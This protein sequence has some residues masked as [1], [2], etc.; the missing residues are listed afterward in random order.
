MTWLIDSLNGANGPIMM[1]TLT[2][3]VVSPGFHDGVSIK[4]EDMAIQFSMLDEILIGPEH[5]G[6]S[7]TEG[8]I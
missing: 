5:E 7:T 4:L 1:E 3:V 2:L 6:V 8:V